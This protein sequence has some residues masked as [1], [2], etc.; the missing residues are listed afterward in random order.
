MVTRPEVNN[1]MVK[2]IEQVQEDKSTQT[3]DVRKLEVINSNLYRLTITNEGAK[4]TT[5]KEFDKKQLKEVY[6][7]VKQNIANLKTMASQ[8]RQKAKILDRLS[9]EDLE[10]IEDFM[11][12]LNQVSEYKDA[13]KAKGAI[14]NIEKQIEFLENGQKEIK[15]ALPEVLRN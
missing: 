2:T 5:V 12:L 14:P 3:E 4:L 8:E 13:E 15:V 9:D 6:E 11:F 10:K 7:E 1:K